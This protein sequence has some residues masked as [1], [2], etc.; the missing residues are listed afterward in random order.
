[1][2]QVFQVYYKYY[3]WQMDEEGNTRPPEVVEE[4]RAKPS[5]E[6]IWIRLVRREKK[7]GVWSDWSFVADVGH[8]KN[9]RHANRKALVV[10]GLATSITDADTWFL[11]KKERSGKG[12]SQGKKGRGSGKGGM[13][14]QLQQQVEQMAK[15]IQ[16]L[17][18]RVV[19]SNNKKRKGLGKGKKDKKRKVDE[20]KDNDVQ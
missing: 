16:Q 12:S 8:L 13:V 14:E 4:L 10:A 20:G 6:R 1:M 11:M 7:S 2:L 18:E 17:Q 9:T 5:A 3:S 19:E 15:Q